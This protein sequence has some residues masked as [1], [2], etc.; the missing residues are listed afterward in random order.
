MPNDSDSPSEERLP[1]E[2]LVAE[3]S[4][5]L[6]PAD[7]VKTA[8]ERMRAL[9]TKTWPVTEDRKLVGA[10]DD[11]NVDRQIGGHG[12]D[13]EDWRVS[14]IM[15][16]DVIFCYE[17]EDCAE[18]DRKMKEHDL[19]HLPVVDRQMRIVGIFS[20]QEVAQKAGASAEA[21]PQGTPKMS[22]PG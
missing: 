11:K 5:A 14:N 20:R 8:C 21:N 7:T 22:D 1:L 6:H 13:P 10:V 9:D 4:G 18:A 19:T 17:D 12:H 3:K 15:S 2:S 16:R